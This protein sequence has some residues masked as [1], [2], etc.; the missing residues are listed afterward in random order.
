MKK[1]PSLFVRDRETGLATDVVTPG[2]EWVTNGEGVATWKWDGTCCMVRGGRLF[3]RYDAKN[4]KT[5]PTN[6]EPEQ[7]PDAITGHWPGW[8]PV[9]DGTADQYHREAFTN[10][11]FIDMNGGMWPDGTYELCG[12][13]VNGNPEGF[14]SHF[15]I[16]HGTRT[17]DA[18]RT[19]SR[20]RE[21]L[22]TW[23]MEGVVFY[24]PDGRMVKV[25]KKDFGF[26]R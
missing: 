16:R 3:K 17:V 7:E 9:G 2:C 15:L 26:K 8:V 12:P 24:H 13:K 1:I 21:W 4:G 25:K 23:E 19:F 6:F 22:A 11:H 18:P 14:A 10:S 5:P 20:L